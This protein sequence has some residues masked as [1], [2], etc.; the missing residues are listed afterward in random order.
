MKKGY[1][2]KD[3]L[4]ANICNDLHPGYFGNIKFAEFLY[5]YIDTH[6]DIL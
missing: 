1:T 5:Q 3:E 2:I 4:G 6:Y